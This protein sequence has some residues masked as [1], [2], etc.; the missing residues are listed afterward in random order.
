MT[1]EIRPAHP[2]ALHQRYGVTVS[3]SGQVFINGIEALLHED[4]SGGL[5]VVIHPDV[6]LLT[7]S[8]LVFETFHR[9]RTE[10]DK[11]KYVVH[12]DNNPKNNQA[13]NLAL[14]TQSEHNR[15]VRPRPVRD[16]AE[17]T[18]RAALITPNR[19]THCPKGHEYSF[20]NTYYR[21]NG[22]RSCR[23]CNRDRDR[24]KRARG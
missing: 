9:P 1:Y 22:G 19:K 23:A 18:R 3:S 12:L 2:P 4:S 7:V 24:R 5:R 6:G 10:G 20:E 17:Q 14:M 13:E 8:H 21:A 15:Y 16:P 11:G